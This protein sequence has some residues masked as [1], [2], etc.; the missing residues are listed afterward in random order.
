MRASTHRT[1]R[2]GT[3]IH[4]TL[5]VGS[6]NCS[7]AGRAKFAGA[8]GALT[9]SRG[10]PLEQRNGRRRG[11]DFG[12]VNEIDEAIAAV[13]APLAATRGPGAEQSRRI[14]GGLVYSAAA[15]PRIDEI[16]GDVGDGRIFF[17]VDE[18][19]RSFVPL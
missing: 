19:H 15:Q 16:G 11:A 10:E 13:G 3:P 17:V 8:D 1:A 12:A 5:I 2:A 7:K 14:A 18:S 4:R 6:R 9:G